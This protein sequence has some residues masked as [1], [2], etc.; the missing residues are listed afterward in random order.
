MVGMTSNCL[1]GREL[2]DTTSARCLKASLLFSCHFFLFFLDWPPWSLLK[3]STNDICWLALEE[4]I[5]LDH[6][7]DQYSMVSI[8]RGALQNH[9]KQV[10]IGSEDSLSAATC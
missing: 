10:K 2:D 1:H 9:L 7:V 5:N 3:L 8:L 6:M 4:L